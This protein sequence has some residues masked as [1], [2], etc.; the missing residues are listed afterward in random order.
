MPKR[1][2]P[3]IKLK[4]EGLKKLHSM[5]CTLTHE[6][7]LRIKQTGTVMNSL[8]TQQFIWKMNVLYIMNLCYKIYLPC[9]QWEADR[10]QLHI[11]STH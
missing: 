8:G 2:I 4:E 5:K 1:D 10:H 7:D 6:N 9:H 3:E 11:S